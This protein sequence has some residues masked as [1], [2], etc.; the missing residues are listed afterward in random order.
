MKEPMT[1]FKLSTKNENKMTGGFTVQKAVRLFS[2]FVVTVSMLALCAGC[3]NSDAT[4][5]QSDP[6]PV[7]TL[8]ENSSGCLEKLDNLLNLSVVSNDDNTLKAEYKAGFIYGHLLKNQI[9]SARDNTWDSSY[10]TDPSHSFP[11]QIPPSSDELYETELALLQNYAYSMDYAQ[12]LSDPTI[13]NYMKR[14]IFRMLGVYHGAVLKQ[15]EALDFSGEWLPTLDYFSDSELQCNYET[16]T[17][18]FMDLY[19]INAQMDLFGYVLPP[20]NQNHYSRCTAFAKKTEDDIFMAH[21]S[22]S[23]FLDQSMAGSFY[24]NGSFCA[25][26]LAAPGLIRSGQ[27]FGY[28]GKGIMFFEITIDNTVNQPKVDAL[29]EVWRSA[30]AEIFSGSMDEFY[31]LI[32]LETSGTYMNSYVIADTNTREIGLVEMSWDTTVYFKPDT[33]AE[34]GYR[35]ITTPEEGVSKEYDPLMLQPDYILGFNDAVSLAIREQLTSINNRPAR[36]WQLLAQIYDVTDIETTKD[37][38]TFTDPYNPLSI[39]GRWDLGYGWTTTPQTVPDG[40]LDAKA[41][42]ASMLANISDLKGVLNVN[43]SNRAFWMKFGTP[44]VDG[45]PFI[46]SESQW[47]E[48]KLRDVPDVVDGNYHYFKTHIE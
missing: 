45:K 20:E 40:S 34:G 30:M 46:W 38:I 4:P 15:P 6:I 41:A 14:L 35:V 33:E 9:I 36:Q 31:S 43:S 28:N 25:L 11:K 32:T 12:N 42:S 39:Y 5:P 48:Q 37:L 7:F 47:S 23:S 44:V 13:Q 24:V 29:W 17:L 26:N 2:T 10:I 22:W 27:D 8:D 21:N 1:R 18:S 3:D 19:F 16:E